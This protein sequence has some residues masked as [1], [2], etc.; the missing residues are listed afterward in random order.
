MKWTNNELYTLNHE[1]YEVVRKNEDI[2]NNKM[3]EA[4]KERICTILTRRHIDDYEKKCKS[5]RENIE[6]ERAQLREIPSQQIERIISKGST[7]V[8]VSARQGS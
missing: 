8:R 7:I 5:A 2:S 4:V 6:K 1:L 3:Y